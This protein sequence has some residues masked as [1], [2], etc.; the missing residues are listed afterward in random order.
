MIFKL[1]YYNLR[2]AI[3]ISNRRL[4]Q[5]STRSDSHRKERKLQRDGST[6]RLVFTKSEIFYNRLFCNI[7][8]NIR[9][10]ALDEHLFAHAHRF[11]YKNRVFGLLFYYFLF[12]LMIT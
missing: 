2:L 5:E 4:I 11:V 12:Y 7:F 10:S 3:L 6:A 9:Q 1:S 8:I